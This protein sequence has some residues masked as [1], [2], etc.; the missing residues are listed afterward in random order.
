LEKMGVLDASSQ[1]AG[2]IMGEPAPG[3]GR[4]HAVMDTQGYCGLKP[5][6]KGH[7]GAR[8]IKAMVAKAKEL[9]VDISFSTPGRRI[10]KANGNITGVYAEDKTGKR[11][12]RA[13]RR[14]SG[15]HR[16]GRIQ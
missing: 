10:L 12:Y 3:S 11:E 13:H 7:G 2:M 14:Q 6:G 16:H 8:L 9:G 15:G 4:F 5:I 1:R